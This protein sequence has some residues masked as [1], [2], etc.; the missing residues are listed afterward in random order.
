MPLSFELFKSPATGG[1]IGSVAGILV[2]WRQL[3]RP[4]HMLGEMLWSFL[5]FTV[6]VSAGMYLHFADKPLD[7]LTHSF[8]LVL[9][10]EYGKR[11][12]ATFLGND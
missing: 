11:A 2:Y 8:A 6:G 5:A 10:L 7:A 9:S 3:P 1:V 4:Q 12:T